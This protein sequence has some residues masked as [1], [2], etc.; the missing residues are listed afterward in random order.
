MRILN[1]CK[2][3]FG[4]THWDKAVSRLYSPARE[5]YYCSEIL[6]D[7]FYHG[8]WSRCTSKIKILSTISSPLYKGADLVLK[9]ALLLKE[10]VNIDLNGT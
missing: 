7:I 3:Y 1:V 9:T 2:K 4:R 10:Y 5:Y 8:E 6:R